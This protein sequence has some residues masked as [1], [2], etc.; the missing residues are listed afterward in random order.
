MHKASDSHLSHH[1]K[2]KHTDSLVSI[3]GFTVHRR[4]RVARRGGGTAIYVH[5]TLH[6]SRWTPADAVDNRDYE[7]LWVRVGTHLFFAALYH[8]PRP[9][10]QTEGLLAY[11]DSCV[12]QIS[13]DFPL[14]DV[15]VAGDLNRLS[16]QDVIERTGLTQIIYQPTR[17]ANI[18]DRVFVSN[19]IYT[20]S[21]G[22]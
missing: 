14:A 3:D 4:D 7:M 6:S 10:Y 21:S 18:L 8:P 11:M 13:H 16:D 1:F 12:S 9:T 19:L 20:L 15:V 22:L 17:G 2:S 5:S